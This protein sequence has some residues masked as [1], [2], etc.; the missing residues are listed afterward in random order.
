[1]RHPSHLAQSRQGYDSAFAVGEVSEVWA[2]LGNAEVIAEF[3]SLHSPVVILESNVVRKNLSDPKIPG[4]H[5]VVV[6]HEFAR[7]NRERT[8]LKLQAVDLSRGQELGETL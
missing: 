3:E 7:L 2:R 8:I 5:L 4:K 6:G 1:M